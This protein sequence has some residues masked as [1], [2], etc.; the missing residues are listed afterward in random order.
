MSNIRI[1]IS[2]LID[3]QSQKTAERI[4]SWVAVMQRN[5]PFHQW[6]WS[7]QKKLGQ[8]KAI[9]AVSLK[10]LKLIFKLLSD[11]VLYDNNVA[12]SNL[13]N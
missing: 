8:K 4:C 10:I 3:C 11:D 5:T 6:F 9:I 1:F 13:K 2:S 12:L 7:H